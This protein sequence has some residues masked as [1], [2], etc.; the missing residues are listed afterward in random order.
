MRSSGRLNFLLRLLSIGVLLLALTVQAHAQKSE[1]DFSYATPRRVVIQDVTVSGVE[2]IDPRVLLQIV[3]LRKGD[4]ISLPG[5]EITAAVK[6]LYSQSL[7][8]NVSINLAHQESDHVILD[9]HVEEQPRISRI[10]YVG[11]KRGARKDL[12]EKLSLKA[13]QQATEATLDQAKRTIEKYYLDKGRI[14]MR[15]SSRSRWREAR[16]L[17]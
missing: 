12:G 4:T 13:G 9:I 10:E 16:K 14:R 5:N 1:A 17:R 3:G 2:Y 15:L 8:S 7:F 11:V 6:K